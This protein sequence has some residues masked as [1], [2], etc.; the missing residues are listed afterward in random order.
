MINKPFTVNKVLLHGDRVY[1]YINTNKTESPVTIEIDLTNKCNNNCPYCTGNRNSKEEMDYK[2]ITMILKDAKDI[3]VRGIVFTGGGEPLLY[4]RLVDVISYAN[5]LGL[6]CGLITSGQ[7][8]FD[9][10]I[11][12]LLKYLVWIRVSLDAGT[13]KRYLQTHGLK[14]TKFLNVINFIKNICEVKVENK[15]KTVIGV[16]YLYGLWN[17]DDEILDINKALDLV[18]QDGLDY[19]Q[20]RPFNFNRDNFEYKSY[21]YDKYKKIKLLNTTPNYYECKNYDYCH[22]TR[23][24]TVIASN[25]CMYICCLK[26]NIDKY[27]IGNLHNKSLKELWNSN[28][29]DTITK[30]IDVKKCPIYCK[31]EIC[32]KILN[33]LYYENK[34][35]HKSFI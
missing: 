6:K 19:F 18:Y 7:T 2:F 5:N 8:E 24:N 30:N 34:S 11:K 16:G 4:N 29:V 20:V 27:K 12:K 17:D 1:E 23:F 22:G 15:L 28:I 25:G 26:R 33:E 9:I 10:D 13:P 14:K 3:G 31:N 35:E 21:M 32:N